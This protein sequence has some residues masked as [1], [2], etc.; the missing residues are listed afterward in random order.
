M[1][2]IE[3]LKLLIVDTVI[4]HPDLKWFMGCVADALN[5]LKVEDIRFYY[6]NELTDWEVLKYCAYRSIPLNI[7]HTTVFVDEV[8]TKLSGDHTNKIL[9]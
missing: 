7:E 5:E 8:F 1:N 2:E 4:E 3:Y 6:A 9:N